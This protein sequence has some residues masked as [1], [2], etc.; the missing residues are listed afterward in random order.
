MVTISDRLHLLKH[1]ITS[2]QAAT[3]LN[4]EKVENSDLIPGQYEGGFK[5]WEGSIDLAQFAAQTLFPPPPSSSHSTTTR[6]RV[7]E[8]GCGHGL[9]GLVALLSGCEVHFQDYNKEVLQQLTIPNAAT[10]WQLQC[11]TTTTT[12]TGN[13]NNNNITNT[14][15]APP[16]ARYF[17]GDW[18]SLSLLM[19]TLQLSGTYD[20]VFSAETV[21]S[22]DS[23]NSLVDCIKKCIKYPGGQAYISGKAYYFGVGGGTRV[24]VQQANGSDGSRRR[25]VAETVA[26]FQDGASN[27]REIIKLSFA[28]AGDDDDQ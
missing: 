26:T 6:P 24:L 14:N 16:Q 28:A 13:N 7:M 17:A 10:N 20:I 12:T 25:M 8:L 19:D 1:S 27:V 15:K 4:Q 2:E 9:P 23:V 3:L 5:L 22:I 18:A 11:T 21:Y